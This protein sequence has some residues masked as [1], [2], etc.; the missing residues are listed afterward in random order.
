LIRPALSDAEIQT[1]LWHSLASLLRSYTAVHGLG[2][3]RQASVEVTEEK[4]SVRHGA[5]WLRL[6]RS[7]AAVIWTR[8]NGSGG[9]LELTSSG[10]LRT[11][12][13]EQAIDLA[14]ESWARELMWE[15][16][17]ELT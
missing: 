5:K 12:E 4:I 9:T 2:N 7:N 3:G 8:E 6:E 10:T 1:E 17:A 14:A 11:P 16:T 13:S 15:H